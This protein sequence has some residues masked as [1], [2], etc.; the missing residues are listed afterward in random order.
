MIS[1]NWSIPDSPGKRGWPSINSA[2]TQPVDQTSARAQISKLS[3]TKWRTFSLTN[4]G[5]V[6]GG[7]KDE[8]RGAVVSGAN[9]RD[10]GLIL[11][12]D[13]GAAKIAELEDTAGRVEKEVLGLNVTMANALRMD[14]GEGTEKLVNVELDLED[15]H[16]G[17]HLVEESR[18]SVNS[19]GNEFLDQVEVD[20]ILL[21]MSLL[22]CVVAGEGGRGAYSFA[23]GIVEGL[24]LDN[25]GVTDNAHDLEFTVLSKF[26]RACHLSRPKR[27]HTLK[28]LSWRTRLI[29]ASSPD[30]E[31]LVWK[32]TPKE[33][34]PTILHWVY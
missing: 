1:T 30:G 5:G 12:E 7:A 8:L 14:V 22:A 13:L 17:L 31:S 2:M 29:A 19:L 24:E 6:V 27:W 9:I 16:G 20:L 15:G 10:V 26:V 34:L 3:Q 28:R 18:S 32:T 21:Y 25:V 11:D 4:L 33:P 23:V